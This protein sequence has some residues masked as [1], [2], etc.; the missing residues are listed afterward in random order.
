MSISFS[1]I[2]IYTRLFVSM[3]KTPKRHELIEPKRLKQLTKNSLQN[4]FR[5]S[6]K[7]L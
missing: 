1:Y 5:N 2:Y 6:R 4:I 3:Q 7:N